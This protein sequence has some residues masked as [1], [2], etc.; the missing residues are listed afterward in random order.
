[1]QRFFAANELSQSKKRRTQR[2]V[3][4]SDS[5]DAPLVSKSNGHVAVAKKPPG[6]NQTS[7]GE[8]DEDSDKP[9][10]VKLR[11]EKAKI[12][13]QAEKEEK[14][15]K[16]KEKKQVEKPEKGKKRIK[17]EDSE[18]DEPIVR[19]RQSNGTKTPAKKAN[20]AVKDESDDDIPLAGKKKAVT[21][22]TTAKGADKKPAKKAA[23]QEE[24][25]EAE[26]EEDE[27]RWWEAPQ[28]GDGTIKWTTLE[29]NG[30]VFPPP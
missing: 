28:K 30:V 22:A 2:K 18:D 21:K 12:E 9:L 27:Y 14:T 20:K 1:L 19:K 7:I 17:Q 10:G 3:L 23:K 11:E 15:L 16:A 25:E 6:I 24:D 29:H 26:A 4:D 8:S 13:K 5:D